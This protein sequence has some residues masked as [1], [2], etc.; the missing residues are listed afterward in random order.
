LI[1]WLLLAVAVVA[2]IGRLVAVALVDLELLLVF[3][4]LWGLLTQHLLV[5]AAR[6]VVGQRLTPRRQAGLILFLVPSLQLVAGLVLAVGLLALLVV[7][8]ALVAVL[9]VILVDLQTAQ[10]LLGKVLMA[11]NV[12]T[13]LLQ[14]AVA[15]VVEQAQLV[16]QELLDKV[17]QAVLVQRLRTVV[18]R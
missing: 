12:L 3:L 15:V 16:E 4:F 2:Q 13:P 1:T 6:L 14:K 11:V 7:M 18:H 10:A 8:E 9:V 17:V 5:L